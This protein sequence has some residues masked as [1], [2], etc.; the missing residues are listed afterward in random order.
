M[1]G[2][3]SNSAESP[4]DLS[5]GGSL[6]RSTWRRVL[7]A[8]AKA[9]ALIEEVARLS[10]QIKMLRV[11][12]EQEKVQATGTVAELAQLSAAH[13]AMLASTSWRLTRPLRQAMTILRCFRR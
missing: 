4:S 13:Q 11:A 6:E 10:G 3:V 8:E 5:R 7:R 1:A 2:P 12:M 9:A